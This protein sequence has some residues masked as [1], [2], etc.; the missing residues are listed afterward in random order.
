M[1]SQLSLLVSIIIITL[2]L[3]ACAS[4]KVTVGEEPAKRQLSDVAQEGDEAAVD[5]YYDPW[6]SY[7]HWM[8]DFNA[9]FDRYVFLPTVSAYKKVVPGFARTGIQNVF[10][11][12]G[13]VSNFANSVLQVKPVQSGTT[14]GRFL[15][16]STIG[17][18]GLWDPATSMGLNYQKEDFGQTLGRWGMGPGPYL[19]LPIAGPSTLR[20][21]PGNII[22]RIFHPIYEPY[23][24]LVDI[25]SEEALAIGVVN[26]IDTR[27]NI[28]F[29]YYEMGS[30]FEYYWTRSLWLEY[31]NLQISK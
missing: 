19:V 18:A 16:N 3:S 15:V 4:T 14:L 7:N 6:E 21:A 27:A 23:P 11:N 12:L 30:P 25:K 31:R 5:L 13:E 17:L 28:G 29:R 22:D 2:V 24:W 26:A 1:K 10:K 9:R 20:D 8:Y